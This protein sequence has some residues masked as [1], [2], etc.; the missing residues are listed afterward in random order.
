[1]E[2]RQFWGN[3][4]SVYKHLKG[5]CKEK[6]ARLLSSVPVTGLEIIGTNRNTGGSPQTSR[7]TFSLRGQL[8]TDKDF[9]ERLW[10]LC[11]WRYS[12]VTTTQSLET[13]C[14]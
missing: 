2:K 7:S 13:S 4:T 3:P 9:P 10:N 1:M 11:P 8:S 6:E 5:G 12:E 14:R